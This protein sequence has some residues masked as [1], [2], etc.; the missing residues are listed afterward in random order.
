MEQ[1]FVNMFPKLYMVLL[2][3]ALASWLIR[4]SVD[5]VVRV[6]TLA[7][8]IVLCSC[9]RIG[10]GA[11]LTVPLSTQGYKWLLANPVHSIRG[12]AR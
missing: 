3:P 4:W 9:I 7:G 10:Q 8:D 2:I 12:P 6:R 11:T 1:K 5:R